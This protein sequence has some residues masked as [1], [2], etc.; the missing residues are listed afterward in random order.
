MINEIVEM[1]RMINISEY[2][3]GIDIS[4]IRKL[5]NKKPLC[6]GFA[7]SKDGDVET[8]DPETDFGISDWKTT[9]Y[10]FKNNFNQ[11]PMINV[12]ISN[13]KVEPP[14]DMSFDTVKS[15]LVTYTKFTKGIT[16]L[17]TLTH[18][19]S[20]KL[21][22]A[23]KSSYPEVVENVKMLDESLSKSENSK[24][25]DLFCNWMVQNAKPEDFK[26]LDVSLMIDNSF[27]D[28]LMLKNEE[29]MKAIS[30]SMSEKLEDSDEDIGL[31]GKMQAGKLT[32]Q[33]YA[34]NTDC[35]MFRRYG[36]NDVNAIPFI[37]SKTKTT[38]YSTMEWLVK[39]ERENK[40][41][42]TI[43]IDPETLLFLFAAENSSD[44]SGYAIE[45]IANL[46]LAEP[47]VAKE[48]DQ[49]DEL[50]D[51]IEKKKTENQMTDQAETV[52]KA[53]MLPK[54]GKKEYK[55][56]PVNPIKKTFNDNFEVLKK[57]VNP[58]VKVQILA[59]LVPKKGA[60]SI[61]YSMQLEAG[62]IIESCRDWIESCRISG[63][64]GGFDTMKIVRVLNKRWTRNSVGSSVGKTEVNKAK[65]FSVIDMFDWIYSHPNTTTSRI[66]DV[67]SSE[68]SNLMVDV[69]F[70]GRSSIFQTKELPKGD[71][72]MYD[73][74]K[75]KAIVAHASK[76]VTVPM[77]SWDGYKLG[78]VIME[79]EKL[80]IAFHKASQKR[81]GKKTGFVPSSKE[82]VHIAF[83]S[84]W[85]SLRHVLSKSQV[86]V[87]WAI[88]Q[89]DPEVLYMVSS[90]R[91]AVSKMNGLDFTV[92]NSRLGIA[93]GYSNIN[94]VR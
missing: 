50:A 81:R 77:K 53:S 68:H 32:I 33:P 71:H 84:P 93:A 64:E 2:A 94:L 24:L 15:W 67:L 19:I 78:K 13:Q 80:Q 42:K 59:I 43:F 52:A 46:S 47:F 10:V 51:K 54:R 58:D 70:S 34:R 66:I 86:Y 55:E 61:A 5:P 9:Q 60:N 88:E 14:T 40:T 45:E 22:S 37:S 27:P 48:N 12:R 36:L 41:W 49:A 4:L 3:S 39:P 72:A 28:C 82:I 31:F 1:G 73:I 57:V 69:T 20:V 83:E 7:F 30:F 89:N 92:G 29:V 35:K 79:F 76:Y 91:Q 75:I 44:K 63:F 65:F 17:K 21:D 18:E 38:V 8:V 23:C 26:H 11:F 6:V 62:S 74:A 56:T 85:R 25:F 87:A 16:K 90:F